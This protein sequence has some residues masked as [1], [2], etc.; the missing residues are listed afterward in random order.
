META[1]ILKDMKEITAYETGLQ[2]GILS[3][4]FGNE[5]YRDIYGTKKE[6]I[7]YKTGYFCEKKDML[8]GIYQKQGIRHCLVFMIDIGEL[9][10]KNHYMHKNIH[11]NYITFTYE[12]FT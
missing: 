2:D 4:F 1:I 3:G 12:T 10:L 7:A 8:T 6:S 9:V 11:S 5:F